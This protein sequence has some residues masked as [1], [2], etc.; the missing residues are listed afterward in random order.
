M[1]CSN[2]NAQHFPRTDPAVIML[3]VRGD[4]CL[5]GHSTRFPNTTCT[6][7]W[8]ASWSRARAWRKRC[9]AR[10]WRR[11]G[12]RSA[13]CA[14]IPRSPGPSPP[15]SC[16]ASMPRACPRDHHRP[17]GTGHARWFSRA[18]CLDPA[19]YG[20]A[21]PRA[22]SIARRLIEDWLAA[23]MRRSLPLSPPC[24]CSAPAA[25]SARRGR[26]CRRRTIRPTPAPAGRGAQQP[27]GP[28]AGPAVLRAQPDQCRPHV[29]RDR[30]GAEPRLS[31]LHAS[32][33]LRA[34]GRR[35][36]EVPR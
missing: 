30:P 1:V 27:G 3:V 23:R 2:C 18:Q 9:G 25:C 34:A 16:S 33:W 28:G 11:R 20:F 19:A 32:P 13:R 26:R 10:C 24:C 31:R 22:D 15:R 29:R 5:L 6:R 35:G 21:L 12:S 14:T 4:E 36:A 8:P 17:R 7:P